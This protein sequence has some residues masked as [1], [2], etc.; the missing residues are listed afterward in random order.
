M[1]SP[2]GIIQI[3][4]PA[5]S[6]FVGQYGQRLSDH[7]FSGGYSNES[8]DSVLLEISCK[9]LEVNKIFLKDFQDP[10]ISDII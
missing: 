1:N 2:D 8:D 7:S 4:T 9:V 3:I 10:K 5:N 6:K